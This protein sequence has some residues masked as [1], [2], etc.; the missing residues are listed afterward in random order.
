MQ[1]E[2]EQFS[3]RGNIYIW[4]YKPAI[5][6]FP[7]WNL[8]IDREGRESIM[9]LFDLMKRSDWPSKKTISTTFPDSQPMW[10]T[11]RDTWKTKSELILN[12]KKKSNEHYWQIIPHENAIEIVFGS[13]KLTEFVNSIKKLDKGINDFAI[14]DNKE[15]SI[16]YF[17]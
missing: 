12:Y 16:L 7:G 4:K 11:S 6:S 14:S 10:A 5:R 2:I 9:L 8:S 17:W 15:E 1:R 3:I 13:S